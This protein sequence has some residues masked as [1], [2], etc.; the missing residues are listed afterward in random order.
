M[1]FNEILLSLLK[2]TFYNPTFPR[3]PA[4]VASIPKYTSFKEAFNSW[5]NPL[6]PDPILLICYPRSGSS[7]LGEV[8]SYS[9]DLKYLRE[10]VRQCL[11]Q[12]HNYHALIYPDRDLKTML[13]TI[14]YADLAFSGLPAKGVKDLIFQPRVWDPG[15]NHRRRLLIKEVNPLAIEFYVKRYNP[16]VLILIRHPAAIADSFHRMGWLSQGWE[17]FAFE[18]GKRMK[19][20]CTLSQNE[21]SRVL[22][23]E[24]IITN[25]NDRI[26][27]LI[28]ELHI[29]KPLDFDQIIE[30]YTRNKDDT[31]DPYQTKR[32]SIHEGDKWR[33][34]L[35]GKIIEKLKTGYLKADFDYYQTD[36]DWQY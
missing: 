6:K 14:R 12:N 1:E 26:S 21:H 15:S 13:L 30:Q 3:F 35:S 31:Y 5:T 9:P 22:V 23:Y 18:Y 25:P 34:N 17:A 7:W 33:N 4:V 11:G 19:M 24:K 28:Q 10:P 32:N 36:A 16:T 20:V 2:H 29:R 27:N 8:L